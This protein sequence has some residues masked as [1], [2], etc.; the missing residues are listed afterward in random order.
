M[1]SLCITP[2][3]AIK[4][5]GCYKKRKSRGSDL[6]ARDK[7]REKDKEAEHE[8]HFRKNIYNYYMKGC[9]NYLFYDCYYIYFRIWLG[10]TGKIKQFMNIKQNK[11]T[12]SN[13]KFKQLI[14]Y[15]GL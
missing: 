1:T 15:T 2:L 9:C 10:Y 13:Y 4:I 14:T 11:Y 3:C 8:T 5:N 7:N 12:S 6:S